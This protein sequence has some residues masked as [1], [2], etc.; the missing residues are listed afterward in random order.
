MTKLRFALL[1]AGFWSRYQL[2]GWLATGLAECIAVCDLKRE[3]AEALAQDFGVPRVYDTAEALLRAEKPDFVDI[4]TSVDTHGPLVQL[5]AQRKVAAVCQKPLALSLNEAEASVEACRR[6]GVALFVNENWRWQSPIRQFQKTLCTG[7]I[8]DVFRARITMVSGFP[9]F[10]NQP[11]LAEIDQFILTDIGSHVLDVARFLFGEAERLYCQTQKV[12]KNIRGEDIAT[13]MLQT[14]GGATI[15]VE[16]GY[17][18]NFLEHDRFPETYIFAEGSRGSAELGP[19]FWIRATTEAGTMAK[20]YPPPRFP[21]ADPAYDVVHS[22]V[23]P[24]QENLAE[25]M[26]GRAAGE[27]T[28]EDNLKTMRLV[29]GAYESAA[30]GQAIR[31][32]A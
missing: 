31:L 15:T 22:S 2:N 25:A 4:C 30:T 5:A 28:G 27:T 13:V 29:F 14:R 21:W 10:R 1:G 3:K 26:L 16:M 17:A 18:E 11:F 6:A 32:P 24:C 8:G 20:R 19:D 12:H 9:V 7:A 23:V